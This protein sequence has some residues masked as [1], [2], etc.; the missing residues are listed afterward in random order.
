MV[1]ILLHWETF[2]AVY[3]SLLMSSTDS[4][5]EIARFTRLTRSASKW[6]F[7]YFCTLGHLNGFSFLN[8]HHRNFP[9]VPLNS[10]LNSTHFWLKIPGYMK[11]WWVAH[12]GKECLWRAFP[13]RYRLIGIQWRMLPFLFYP[14]TLQCVHWQH[15]TS[16]YHLEDWGIC[17]V[18]THWVA[19]IQRC[20]DITVSPVFLTLVSDRTWPLVPLSILRDSSILGIEEACV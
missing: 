4:P 19:G 14:I 3:N 9:I 10:E 20:S 15:N 7:W 17:H 18:I 8:I 5:C 2:T 13:K 1:T 6:I 11:N 12:S 16:G